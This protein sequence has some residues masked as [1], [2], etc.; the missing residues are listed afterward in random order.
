[1][2]ISTDLVRQG[3]ERL[4]LAHLVPLLNNDPVRVVRYQIEHTSHAHANA[5]LIVWAL[6][7]LPRLLD[8]LDEL[9]PIP[10]TPLRSLAFRG[11]WHCGWAFVRQEQTCPRCGYAN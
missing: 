2:N 10:I 6:N 1:M 9:E 3:R 11:C 7:N 8:R 5:Q 4:A